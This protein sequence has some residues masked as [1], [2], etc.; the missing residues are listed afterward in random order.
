MKPTFQDDV[1]ILYHGEALAVLRTLPDASVDSVVTDPPYGLKFMGK[2]WDHGTPG[3]EFWQ[4]VL[5]VAK[6]GAYLLAFGG[7]R[8]FHRLACAI[9][10]AGWILQD[11]L[12]W[13]YG[14][15]FPKH[16][17]K[18]KPA[19]EPIIMAWKPD[20]CATPLPGLDAC[21]IGSETITV[22]VRKQRFNGGDYAN[23]NE[24]CPKPENVGESQHQGRW[25]ANVV[26]SHTDRCVC[27][28]VKK[29]KGHAGYPN[30]PKGN[31]FHGGVGRDPDGSRQ[32]AVA[33]H[34]DADGLETVEA[35]QCAEDCPVRM[36]DEQ[37]WE[38]RSDF[39]RGSGKPGC[40]QQGVTETF[41]SSPRN[42][43]GGASRFFYC[44]K[45]SKRGREEGNAHPTVKP[46]ALMRW[47]CRLITPPGGIILDP[48]MGSG[49]T[50]IAAIEEKFRFIGI[51][52]EDAYFEIAKK[53]ITA[54]CGELFA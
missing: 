26:L 3:T 54:P 45:A 17:S 21:R 42:D 52:R 36:L 35:W 7:T 15:G 25:P 51:E 29:V 13:L 10:D 5:R 1:A 50:G 22:G 44:A 28:G 37:S 46:T 27:V 39:A 38:L 32:G 41:A 12:C 24:Y 40:F 8:T 20:R 53:R 4:E 19:W 11:T 47:L 2:G 49:S 30:G 31:G 9:E 16:K 23:G 48:F 14:Q 34:A 43:P 6:P 18:L 33:G